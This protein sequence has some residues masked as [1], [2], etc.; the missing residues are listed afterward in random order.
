M[1]TSQ[2]PEI[3]PGM[4]CLLTFLLGCGKDSI[5][6]PIPNFQVPKSVDA[7]AGNVVSQKY[8]QLQQNPQSA[9]AWS[10]FADAC[11]ANE[12]FA[13]AISAYE[14][15][16]TQNQQDAESIWR[17][18]VAFSE[19]GELDRAVDLSTKH[20]ELFACRAECSRRIAEWHFDNGDLEQAKARLADRQDCGFEDYWMDVLEAEILISEANFE[21]AKSVIQ[22]YS[23]PYEEDLYRLAELTARRTEDNSWLDSLRTKEPQKNRIPPDPWIDS[24]AP[25]NRTVLADRRRAEDLVARPPNQ[26]T[27]QQ[28][29]YLHDARPKDSWFAATYA[30]NLLQLGQ[31]ENAASTLGQLKLDREQWTAEYWMVTALVRMKQYEATPDESTA[32][33]M[34][35]ASLNVIAVDPNHV[36]ATKT[37]AKAYR[38]LGNFTAEA[39]AWKAASELASTAEEQ[40]TCLGASF[41]ATGR[42]GDWT[43]A[44]SS[45]DLL[46][47][48]VPEE[49]A[50]Q[51][52]GPAAQAAINAGRRSQ[53]QLYIERLRTG[54]YEELAIQLE[55][56]LK[57]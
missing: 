57:Q 33:S 44:S 56:R 12:M 37:S 15:I 41:Q 48:E 13:D 27:S 19:L 53:A 55:Q 23:P 20:Q 34:L 16:I 42:A 49:Q 43:R 22:Q 54:G 30:M 6:A 31:I 47:E 4:L 1:R 28:L 50:K 2:N 14:I 3:W 45:F 36:T 10:T 21:G 17:C 25:L 38:L 51:F 26:Q 46:L 29:R 52:W 40:L 32:Q 8:M 18:A 11:L 35:E 9:E 5:N 7:V 24:L 39:E